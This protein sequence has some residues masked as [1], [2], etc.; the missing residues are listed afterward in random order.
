MIGRRIFRYKVE[1]YDR[2]IGLIVDKTWC[3]FSI[4]NFFEMEM[5]MFYLILVLSRSPSFLNELTFYE[6]KDMYFN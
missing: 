1:E 4:N 2:C 3:H 6:L 5:A